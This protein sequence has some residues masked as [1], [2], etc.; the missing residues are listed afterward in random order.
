MGEKISLMRMDEALAQR[1]S[2]LA[3]A[4]PFCLLMFQEAKQLS[5]GGDELQILDLAQI[6]ERQLI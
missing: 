2:H 6:V 5:R 4:C 3:T 1:P